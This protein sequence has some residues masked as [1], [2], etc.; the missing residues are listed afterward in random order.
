MT[1][2][3]SDVPHSITS[4]PRLEAGHAFA[5][6]PGAKRIKV[7]FI[8]SDLSIGGAEMMLYKLLATMDRERFEPVVVSLIDQGVLREA[9]EEL[10]ITVHTAG[11]RL[12]YPSLSGLWRLVRLVRRLRPALIIGW[13]YHSSLAAQLA[14]FLSLRRTPVLWSIHYCV[15]SLAAEKWLTAAVIRACGLLSGLPNKIV[16]VSRAGLRQHKA[17]GYRVENSCMIPNGIDT[18]SFK[19]SPGSRASVRAGLGLS[20][21][22]LLIGLVGRYHPSKD[23]PNFLRAAAHLV[24]AN[25]DLHFLLIGSGVDDNN[26]VLRRTIQ[27]LG[28]EARTHLLGERHDVPRLTA[29]L[30]IF[31]LASYVESFPNVIGEAMACEVPCVVTD[32]GDAALIVGDTGRVV[33]AGDALALARACQELI[34]LGQGGRRTLGQAA[35]MRVR[36]RFTLESVTARYESL[37]EDVLAE[38]GQQQFVPASDGFSASSRIPKKR[39]RR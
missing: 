18:Q 8:I 2:R 33:P 19:P 14:N 27:E 39:G 36:Q 37:Y 5:S 9:I 17:L 26:A 4:R 31:S 7:L 6:S 23:Y 28:L 11:M 1:T 21:D 3:L 29:A 16:F 15:K 13:M 38:A 25:P 32:V 22:A 10:G 20:A 24:E 35:R 30:D 12:G 34:D